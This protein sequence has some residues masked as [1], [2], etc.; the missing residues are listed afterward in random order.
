MPLPLRPLFALIAVLACGGPASEAPDD[1]TPEPGSSSPGRSPRTELVEYLRADLELE[2]HASDGGGRAWLEEGG[3]TAAVAGGSGRWTIVYEAGPLGIAEGGRLFLQASPFWDWSTPQVAYPDR[4]GY[5]EATTAAE[6]VELAAETLDR[7]LLGIRIGGRALK[8]G[9]RVRIVYG[10]GPALARTDRYA[11]RGSRLW[12]AVDGDGDGVRGIVADSPSVEVAA[13]PPARLLLILPS[14]ARPGDNLRLTAAVVDRLGNAGVTFSGEIELTVTEGD[15][16]VYPA[17]VV[18]TAVDRGR[19]TVEITPSEPGIVRLAAAGPDG[20]AAESNPLQV[21]TA[22]ARILWADL[23]NHSNYSDGTGVPEDL[24]LY[25]RDVAALD[26]FTLTDHDHWGM[27]FLDQQPDMWEEIQELTKRFHDPGRF[28]T[29]LGFEWTNW[30]Y[31]H[32]HVLY[33]ED[34]GEVHSSI[35]PERETPVQLW[36]ALR[37]SGARAMTIAHHSAGGPVSIDWSIPPDPEFEPVTEIVSVHGSSEAL[38]TPSLIYRPVPGNF[39]RDA[40]GLGYRLG[41]VGSSDSHDGHPGLAHL[42]SPSSGLAAILA[43]DATR[44]AV[45]EALRSR[46]VY[47]TSGQR[48][49][50][51]TA[52]AG[53]PMGST[54]P[55]G[56]TGGGPSPCAGRPRP[57]PPRGEGATSR[58]EAPNREVIAGVPA[59]TLIAQVVA[60]GEL[61]VLEVVRSGEIVHGIDCQ[62]E[63]R[64]AFGLELDDLRPGEYVYVR[65]VQRD[66]AAAWSSPFFFVEPTPER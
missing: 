61:D 63:R 36:A 28:V 1:G 48:I 56:A 6:G 58:P 33:F 59:D 29:L 7:Q 46:R 3:S 38:D 49:L 43:E 65:A 26:V 12:I 22:G 27:R 35:D 14:T 17:K 5:T 60:P 2:R 50:L 25:A 42:A 47:A 39:V 40:L 54:I 57:S 21:S 20:L 52:F 37:E 31:G 64:C 55:V 62:G 10:A 41:F 34:R 24:F 19:K 11:E 15:G 51:R 16:V 9:E 18:F 23:H 53:H 13:G 66:G 4:P 8:A 32:R 45:Y 44:E 30:V